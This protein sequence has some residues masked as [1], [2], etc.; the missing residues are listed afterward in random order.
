MAACAVIFAGPGFFLGCVCSAHRELHHTDLATGL[1]STQ[2]NANID[3]S[4]LVTST[5]RFEGS[6]LILTLPKYHGMS[7][8]AHAI[9]EAL[10]DINFRPGT[11]LLFD[12][13]LSEAKPTGAE[14]SNR[15]AWLASLRSKGISLRCAF[16]IRPQAFRYGLA[17][18]MGLNLDT[19]G[20]EAEIFTTMDAALRW[21]ANQAR[22]DPRQTRSSSHRIR[23][24]R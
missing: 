20:M 7:D 10:A 2:T 17:R 8:M 19:L 1:G 3:N 16:V 23:R 15:A 18:M 12:A 22:G 5:W 11:S 13:R 14:V 6:I 24:R 4:S 21:L 9:N